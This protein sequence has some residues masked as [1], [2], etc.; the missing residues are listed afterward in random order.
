MDISQKILSDIVVF[1]KYA[2]FI[3]EISR[4][5]SWEELVER[6]QAMHMRK[7]PQLKSEI[8]K[9]Y[10]DFV[11][12]KKVLPSMRSLQFG[13]NS[14]ELSNNRLYNCAYMPIDHPDAFS[15]T[16][17]LLLGGSGVGMGVQTHQISKLPLVVGPKQ[18]TRRFLV[19]DSIEGWADAIKILVEA[20]FYNKA[21]PVF[22]YR[23][24]RQKGARLVTSG[25]KAPGPGPLRIC[26]EQIRGILSNAIGRKICSLEAHDIE[27]HIA[28]AV[29][30]GGIRRAAMISLFSKDDMDMLCC[31]SGPWWELNPQRGRANNSIVLERNNITDEEFFDIWERVEESGAGEP[32]I[33]WTND[34]DLGTNPCCEISLNPHQ[35]CN[36]TEVNV[37]DVDSQEELNARVRAAAFLGT[38]QAGYTDF[39][40]LRP[41]W[42]EM[43]KK[44]SLIGV[45]M[46]GIGSGTTEKLN[47]KE[48]ADI[49]KTENARIAEIIGIN[50][51]ARTTTVKPSGCVTLDTKIRT[52]DGDKSMLELF[53]AA[54]YDEEFLKT[55]SA[56]TWLETKNDAYIFDENNDQQCITKFYVNGMKDVFEIEFID[57]NSY[58]FT[59]NHQ[60]KTQNG[61]KRVDEL[62]EEDEIL[63]FN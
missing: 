27:C 22:D 7:Y 31:K 63:D 61:W 29:L 43:T 60:L 52:T 9:V 44:E 17:F 18:K 30:S 55:V 20:Y 4:R 59:G 54:G 48:A 45:G 51:A 33:F 53:S 3:P 32:G 14:I 13:G 50:S 21:E 10:K 5:E 58:K 8:K 15:E 1:Q 38:L 19:G 42:E 23:D 16:M 6:N 57:G 2:R 41:E 25:G 35:F 62:T 39:H 49:V 40:Y 26:I 36:L 47:L 24:I 37:S 56:G 34:L 28:D 12:S 46:T 11:M